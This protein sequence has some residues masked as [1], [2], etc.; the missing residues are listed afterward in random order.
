[1]SIPKGLRSALLPLLFTVAAGEAV[2]QNVTLEFTNAEMEPIKLLNGT[3]V[4]IDG[5]GNL[6]A[7]CVLAPSGA[8]CDG[9]SVGNEGNP[10]VVTLTRTN[11]TGDINQNSPLALSWTAQPAAEVCLATSSPAIA[12]WNNTVVA[13]GGGNASL[14]MSAAGDFALGLK[15][16]NADGV[17]NVATLNVTVK[18]SSGNSANIP[19]CNVPG[20]M[21]TGRVQPAGFT[22]HHRTWSQLFYGAQFPHTPSY[23]APV[24]SFTLKGILDASNRGPN[25]NARYITTPFTPAPNTDYRISWLGAQSIPDAGYGNPRSASSVFVSVSPCAGDLR[26]RQIGGATELAACRNQQREAQIFFSTK[27]G[28]NC[29]LVAGQE[30][31]LTIAFVDTS[32][33]APLSTTTTTCASGNRCEGNFTE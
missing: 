1:M 8:V 15:C 17:S 28:H 16:Y 33:T 10:P 11:G 14:T 4:G 12:G 5:E 22:G 29:E 3:S 32:G 13:A 20:L 25:M 7:Q 31:W 18:Q 19:A 9:I 2:A 21:E 6:T 23:L 30:Y 24:G 26:G 27:A